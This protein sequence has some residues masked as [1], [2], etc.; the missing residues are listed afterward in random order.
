MV[1]DIPSNRAY[2]MLR[3]VERQDVRKGIIAHRH[4]I[5]FL[6]TSSS[7]A[8][9]TAADRFNGGYTRQTGQV[10]LKGNF[11]LHCHHRI[12]RGILAGV[13]WGYI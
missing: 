2:H 3:S 9:Q 6:D 10:F 8:A 1:G 7:V 12:G 4:C 5:E 13:V 11:L